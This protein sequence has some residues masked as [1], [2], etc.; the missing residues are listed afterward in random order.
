MP[1]YPGGLT[2]FD[3][4]G[5]QGPI[6]V[7]GG[8]LIHS[9]TGAP[10][11]ALGSD[12]DFYIRQDA[13]T[14]VDAVLVKIAGV[15]TALSTGLITDSV[16]VAARDQSRW[17]QNWQAG[18][19]FALATIE[20]RAVSGQGGTI[21]TTAQNS[22]DTTGY[23]NDNALQYEQTSAIVG[24]GTQKGHYAVNSYNWILQNIYPS[25]WGWYF[26]AVCYVGD[27]GT[28]D[29]TSLQG[30]IA[31]YAFDIIATPPPGPP[32]KSGIIA[33]VV[34]PVTLTWRA[35][36]A[37]SASAGDVDI[38]VDSN[39]TA[40]NQSHFVEL[41]CMPGGSVASPGEI[42]FYL[43]G[44]LIT[45][46]TTRY[47]PANHGFAGDLDTRPGMAIWGDGVAQVQLRWLGA[48]AAAF[49]II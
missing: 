41:V 45:T 11:A 22:G 38:Q 30:V 48:A 37:Y 4:S 49:P 8:S 5:G 14:S 34:D 19:L 10:A 16:L 9:G 47:P 24:A 3:P 1:G 31:G 20:N 42:R 43:D 23:L 33:W 27:D 39:V 18:I 44:S 32:N 7:S 40:I 46:Q 21:G 28:S 15:W 26:G 17:A 2:P 25:F 29:P 35:R 12:G 13:T 6:E 36:L